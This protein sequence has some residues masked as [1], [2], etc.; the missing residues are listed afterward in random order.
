MEESGGSS[1][2][3][4]VR[5]PTPVFV[6]VNFGIFDQVSQR[7]QAL[8]LQIITF[9]LPQAPSLSLSLSACACVCVY[10]CVCLALS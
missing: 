7:T 10:V 6:S 2:S 5:Q 9:A 3:A 8:V 4:C 1:T